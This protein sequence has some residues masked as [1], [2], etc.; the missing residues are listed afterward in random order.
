M[1]NLVHS[2]LAALALTGTAMAQTPAF[3]ADAKLL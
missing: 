1:R 3:P 2:V